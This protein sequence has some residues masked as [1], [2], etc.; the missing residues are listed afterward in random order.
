MKFFEDTHQII[1]TILKPR[2]YSLLRKLFL[3]NAF[4]SAAFPLNI[5]DLRVVL[6]T[7][8]KN[9]YINFDFLLVYHLLH[10]TK[11]WYEKTDG[12]CPSVGP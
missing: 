1:K 7:S 10:I 11:P 12:Q 9:Y 8:R 2:A 5:L 4:F 6:L 3:A